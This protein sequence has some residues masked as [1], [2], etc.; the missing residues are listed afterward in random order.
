MPR[1]LIISVAFILSGACA[2]TLTSNMSFLVSE[3]LRIAPNGYASLK[4]TGES[5]DLTPIKS[6]EPRTDRL[7]ILE[8]H[9][10]YILA[11]DGWKHVWTLWNGGKDEMHYKPLSLAPGGNGFG[12][13]TLEPSGNCALL[14][15]QKGASP[16]Q[17]YVNAD[18]DVN[19]KNCP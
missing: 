19:E 6:Q 13:P 7:Q 9:G 4:S 17:A 18:G 8:V 15:W 5:F 2:P 14:K 12:Q 10:T 3:E 11:A 1:K 16:A